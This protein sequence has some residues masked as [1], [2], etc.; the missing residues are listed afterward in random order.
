MDSRV[1]VFGKIVGVLC[2]AFSFTMLPPIAV[3]IWFHDTE[4]PD[5]I[6]TFLILLGTG[7]ALWLLFRKEIHSLH[8]RDGFL[9]VAAFWLILSL[10]SSLPLALG[11]HHLSIID[12][13]FEATSGITTTGATVITDLEQVPPS[14]L[15]YRQELQWI[16]GMGLIVLAIAILPMLGIG[17]MELYRAE[18]PGPMKNER[19]TPRL[20]QTAR[21]LWIIYVV[22]TICCA[23]AYWLAGLTPLDALEHSFSTISTGGFST[24]NESFAYFNSKTINFISVIFMIAGGINFGIHF[25]AIRTRNPMQYLSDIEVRSFLMILFTFVTLLALFLYFSHTYENIFDS[26]N[27]SLFEVTSVMTSTGFG[28]ADF[29]LW[30]LFLPA[31]LIF[32]SFIGGCGGS[33]AG[34]IKVMRILTL[35]KQAAHEAFI[36]VHPKAIRPVRIGNR[37][38][39]EKTTQAIW[40]FFALYIIVFVVMTLCM[41]LAGLDQVSA[42]AA[43]ATCINNLGPGLGEVSAT[44]ANVS[45]SAKLIGTAAMLLGRLEIFTLL[46]IL[47]PEFWRS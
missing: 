22:L 32:I 30:P 23:V 44:F 43:V 31:L 47:T 15:F 8:R 34:G 38:L 26:I 37:I 13:I 35:F 40:G 2:I 16:G 33:T 28:V 42:F 17:G 3:S 39:D 25:L 18:T 45:D 14:I 46:I 24:H 19:I 6:T 12:S 1:S 7:S 9:I 21:S 4:L 27:Y 36:L 5:F 11:P 20:A 41:M 29:T 10:C